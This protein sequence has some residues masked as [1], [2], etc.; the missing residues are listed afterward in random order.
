MDI[1]S[2]GYDGYIFRVKKSNVSAGVCGVALSRCQR[3]RYSKIPERTDITYFHT[4]E[5]Y[6]PSSG[7]CALSTCAL[8]E[9]ALRHPGSARCER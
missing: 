5:P 2:V 3:C 9:L 8:V 7:S 6:V 4:E 1:R